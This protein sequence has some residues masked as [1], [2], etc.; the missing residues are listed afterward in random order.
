MS[1]IMRRS[2]LS[3][4]LLIATCLICS[5]TALQEA[6]QRRQER[7]AEKNKD[8]YLLL[9]PDKGDIQ[10]G[11][12]AI[13][14]ESA[15]YTL[16]FSDDLQADKDFDEETERNEFAQ[17]ALGYMESLYQQMYKI[18]GF[19]PEHK[20]H[21]TLHKVYQGVTTVATTTTQYRHERRGDESLKV[22]TGIGMDFPLAMYKQP[23]VRVHELTH[24]FTNI[25]FL[26]TWFNEGI[27]VMMQ[28]EWAKD[29]GHPKFMSL[30]NNIKRNL[31]GVNDLEDW[32]S[33]GSVSNLTQWRYSY[34]YTIVAEL[35]K[36]F[37]NDFYLKVFRLME[38]DQ[39]HNK[40]PSKMST[41]FLIYYLS[42]A[43]GTDLVPF[44]NRL[45]F[46]ARKLTKQDILRHI[47]GR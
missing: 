24:A 39:L 5:C 6:S 10:S 16:T 13:K 46:N 19:Q 18:Y 3:V 8:R 47:A 11:K 14:S 20:I 41:S 29:K 2:G 28:T 36:R 23:G 17:S 1:Y 9:T 37:G 26:P 4:L 40:L 21:V 38:A 15:H 32:G 22:V 7:L 31:D 42:Q 45:H 44:F 12:G 25:Y 30:E 35:H 27:A 33:H 34:A 43:A